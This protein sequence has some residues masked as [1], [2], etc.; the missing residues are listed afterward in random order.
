MIKRVDYRWYEQ[1]Q[2]GQEHET[3]VHTADEPPGCS[4]DV[5]LPYVNGTNPGER[6]DGSEV[7]ETFYSMGLEF[8]SAKI[9]LPDRESVGLHLVMSKCAKLYLC[10]FTC[11]HG[12]NSFNFCIQIE[13]ENKDLKYFSLKNGY[14]QHKF[15][16]QCVRSMV[17]IRKCHFDV[18]FFLLLLWVQEYDNRKKRSS[19]LVLH[20][21]LCQSLFGSSHIWNVLCTEL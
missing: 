10:L 4:F 1:P 3:N 21:H 16:Y 20:W 2:D 15:R 13:I 17:H 7:N 12:G 9:K 6:P 18:A 11:L 14:G 19:S 8:V 5:V